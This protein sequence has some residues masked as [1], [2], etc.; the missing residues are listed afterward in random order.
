MWAFFCVC[1]SWTHQNTY[2]LVY[3]NAGPS[4]SDG[5]FPD[6]SD[7]SHKKQGKH[8]CLTSK[9]MSGAFQY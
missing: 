5:Y 8:R 2:W 1:V 4:A 7:I 6:I 3:K 9:R